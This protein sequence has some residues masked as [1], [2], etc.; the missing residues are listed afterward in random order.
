MQKHDT[1][2]LCHTNK[3]PLGQAQECVK[4]QTK[5]GKILDWVGMGE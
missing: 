5:K 4:K 1:L 2:N 3:E